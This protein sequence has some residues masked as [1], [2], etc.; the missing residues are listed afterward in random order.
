[1]KFSYK[2]FGTNS[3]PVIP[4][5]VTY[6]GKSIQYEVLIDSGADMCLFHAELG[7]FLGIDIAKGKKD[8]VTGVGG[9][10]SQ[11][12]YHP[13]TINVGGWDFNIKAGFLLDTGGRK[14][15]YGI[16]GQTGFFEYFKVLFDKSKGVIE[17]KVRE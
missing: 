15:P 10:S 9:K 8:I 2:N 6:K 11:Y 13:V 4:I 12:V 5:K 17:L 16:V 14:A 3:R 1:M 7:E